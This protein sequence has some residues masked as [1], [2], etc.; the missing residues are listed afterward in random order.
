MINN[1]SSANDT[2]MH[3]RDTTL[4][5]IFGSLYGVLIGIVYFKNMGDNDQMF[6]CFIALFFFLLSLIFFKRRGFLIMSLV[7][8]CSYVFISYS[9]F[10]AYK[11]S[12]K[13]VRENDTSE[14]DVAIKECPN[15]ET[16]LTYLKSQYKEY[17]DYSK[18]DIQY[19]K[20]MRKLIDEK[21][22]IVTSCK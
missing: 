7:F 14:F 13:R 18:Y 9:F 22:K 16:E 6:L 3:Q 19:I 10:Q 4:L 11:I 15:H 20:E 21:N 2:D 1:N 5:G 8:I 12:E 17:S